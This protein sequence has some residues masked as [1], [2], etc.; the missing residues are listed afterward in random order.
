MFIQATLNSHT[1]LEYEFDKICFNSVYQLDLCNT[2]SVLGCLL[3]HATRITSHM[4]SIWGI[5]VTNVGTRTSPSKETNSVLFPFRNIRCTSS[6]HHFCIFKEYWVTILFVEVVFRSKSSKHTLLFFNILMAWT[7]SCSL[8][9]T[10]WVY[11]KPM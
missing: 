7:L 2:G 3:N 4:I 5:R 1:D 10:S 9:L 6:L 8:L 11:L